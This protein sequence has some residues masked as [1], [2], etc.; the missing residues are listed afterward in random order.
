M[1]IDR[2]VLNKS[3][4]IL[5]FNVVDFNF[6]RVKMKDMKA[7]FGNARE[8]CPGMSEE[9]YQISD[10]LSENINDEVYPTGMVIAL[11]CVLDDIQ[12]GR[13]GF[14]SG[15]SFPEYF[16]THRTQTLAQAC[17]ILQV[18]DA[19]TDAAFAGEVRADCENALQW[20]VPKR[21]VVSDDEVY[22]PHVKAAVD[23]WAETM[24]H[25]KM[26]NGESA[27][28]VLV[29]MVGGASFTKHFSESEMKV[30]RSTLAAGIMA[31]LARRS[32]MMLHVDYGPDRILGEAGMAA[33]IK[34]QFAFPCKTY[35][36]ISE[37]EVTVSCGYRAPD[38][39]IW[40]ASIAG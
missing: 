18:I 19:V 32:S 11:L 17:Y 20:I 36:M 3:M 29:A 1:I 35:M 16:I 13:C 5:Q 9:V 27:F 2:S 30:F 24:Q 21:V 39:T 6:R 4:A 10:Y 12:K 25:P 31:E 38:E 28:G 40:R 34:S 8:A 22:P 23:W 33:G 26:D 37:K 14:A 7:R 15:K